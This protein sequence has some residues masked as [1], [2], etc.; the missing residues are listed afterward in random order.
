M[1]SLS[2]RR[3]WL[4]WLALVAFGCATNPVTGRKELAL[5]TE[6]QEIAMGQEAD[7]QVQAS[8]GLYQ[9]P[10]LQAYVSRL[11]KE[12]AARSE[13][14]HLPWTFRVVDDASVN[15]FALPGG[16]IY[17]TR[18]IMTHLNSEA[19]LI[20]VLGHEIGHVTARHS[21]SQISK[22]QLAQIGLVLATILQP[23]AAAAYGDLAQTGL[24]VLFLKYSRDD[25]RQADDLGLRY[26]VQNGYDPR[27]MPEVFDVLG[28]VSEGRG[29]LPNWLSSHPDPGARAE[30]ASTAVAGQTLDYSRLR[31]GRDD[32]LSQI[33]GVVFGE[34][35]REGYFEG[36]LFLHPALRF[37]IRFPEGWKTQNQ[38]QAVVAVSP[39]EDAI[40]ALTLAPGESAE[41][42]ARHFLSQQG[43]QGR[44]AWRNEIGGLPAVSYTF[45][46][47]TQNAQ[48]SGVAAWVEHGD[49]VFRLLGYTPSNR[50][51]AYGDTL[52]ASLASFDRVTD[53]RVLNV[54]PRR[55]DVVKLRDD[56]TLD[57]FVREYPS[58]VPVD[59]LALINHLDPGERLPAGEAAKRVTGGPGR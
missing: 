5:M 36:S 46:A 24:S 50:F 34:D 23:E 38:K 52:A 57:E 58:S 15:A 4:Y 26:M 44:Q 31:V 1:R 21:V 10:E 12:L 11:G 7:K 9:D 43:I 28:R 35:P 3:K 19:E 29:R 14:P 25:E 39:R 32:F 48:L 42:A 56:A 2:R 6:Q 8:I 54:E 16:F 33:D 13:R 53:P 20:S 41:Q 22:A 18:G 45:D 30:R 55:V 59:T 47:A 27:S 37:Q 49:R 17:V 40:V 51:R